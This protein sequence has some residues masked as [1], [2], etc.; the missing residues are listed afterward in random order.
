VGAAEHAAELCSA[1]I[2]IVADSR[3]LRGRM[4]RVSLPRDPTC[5]SIA[6]RS[7]EDFLRGY[8]DDL[9]TDAKT[10]ASE[11]INNAYRHGQGAI[12]LKVERDP[13]Y[14]RVDVADQGPIGS[15]RV[16]R[17]RGRYGLGLVDALSMRWGAY[18]GSTHVWAELTTDQDEPARAI[19]MR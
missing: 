9:V 10:V 8:P 17:S 13:R 19:A 4:L 14:V 11:L 18:A 1:A 16:W 5:G 15:A 7:L 6:R 12:E 2:R 3:A